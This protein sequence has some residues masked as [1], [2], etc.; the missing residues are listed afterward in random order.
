MLRCFGVLDLLFFTS[1]TVLVV[2][3]NA[4]AQLG[5]FGGFPSL[6]LFGSVWYSTTCELRVTL[7]FLRVAH[8]DTQGTKIFFLPLQCW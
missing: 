3:A 4:T 8:C 2:V 6:R 7:A 1:F 5:A